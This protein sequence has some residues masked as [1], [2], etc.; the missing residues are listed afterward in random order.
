MSPSASTILPPKNGFRTFLILWIT[1]SISAMGTAI[2]MFTISIWM[3]LDL[4]PRPE[5]KPQ[6]A[7]ALAL[8]SIVDM[9]VMLILAPIAGAW[10]DRHDRKRTMMVADFTSAC[11]STV[12]ALL[13]L[14]HHLHLWSL[15]LL[16]VVAVMVGSFHNASFDASYAMIVPEKQLPRANGMMQTMWSLS[17]ILSPAIAATVISLPSLARQGLI[18]GFF[19]HMLSRFSDGSFLA[20]AL[21]GMSFLIAGTTL[22]F[23]YVPSPKR[24]DL[25]IGSAKAKGRFGLFSRNRNTAEDNRNG[26]EKQKSIWADV[27]EGAQYIWF[28]RSLLWLLGIFT[29]ANFTGSVAGVFPILI[30]KFNLKDNI[31]ELHMSLESALA[32]L[33]TVG[34]IGGVIGGVLMSLW[35]GLKRNRIYGVIL[36]MIVEGV[37]QFFYGMSPWFYLTAGMAFIMFCTVPF[38]NAHSQT[39]W[40]TQTPKE[41]QGRV[42]AVRRVIAQFTAPLG[43]AVAGWAGGIFNPGTVMASLGVFLVVF[44]V[45]QLFNPYLRRVE[46]KAWLDELAAK[47]AAQSGLNL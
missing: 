38:M 47:R 19:A 7:F 37:A 43:M 16:N 46:D 31:G 10:A 42:F 26:R 24:D 15:L 17:G 25:E 4:Y 18:P 27:K 8:V 1:Q 9:A 33:N 44:C 41:L 35:G 3:S 45:L 5:Q 32:V 6:L 20:I 30:L 36:P 23:Q 34:S 39:I 28:R 14:T 29:V 40:Q 22:I 13:M 12:A 21:D 11:I 2:T